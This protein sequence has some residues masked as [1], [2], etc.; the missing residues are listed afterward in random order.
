MRTLQ[1][2]VLTC[3]GVIYIKNAQI[4]TFEQPDT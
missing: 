2:G 4:K 1:P 3:G